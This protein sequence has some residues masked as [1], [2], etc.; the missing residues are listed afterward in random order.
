MT[1]ARTKTGEERA[2]EH[3]ADE[4]SPT[5][6]RRTDY[7]PEGV[8]H[9]TGGFATLKRAVKEFSEDNM[10]DWAAALTYYGLLSLFPALIAL[11]SIVGIFGDPQSTTQK[12]TDIVTQIGPQSAADTFSDPIKTITKDRGA[13][14]VLLIVG[15]LAALWSASGYTGAYMRASNII[16]ET[17]EGR[18]FW[19]ARPLQMLVTLVLIILMVVI[20]LSIALTGPIVEAVADPLG[21]GSTAVS[22]WEI[23]KWPV[24][25][26]LFA[27]MLSILNYMAPNV[28]QR[29]FKLI[30]AGS[31]FAMVVWIL[32]SILFAFYVANFGSYNKTY[33]ALG[34][35]ISLLVWMWITNVAILL[36]NELNAEI[37]RS[38]ELDEGVPRADREIQLKPRDEPKNKQTT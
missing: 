34:G 9:E 24:L 32:A 5:A 2:E 21:V 26:L 12:V 1:D 38:K 25:I 4:E 29:S 22:V 36:G 6:P 8:P 23:A 7:E 11:V 37:E 27:L 30:T 17:P 10:T 13:A 16:W 28:K 3:R 33:G 31:V 35:L 18:P 14:G 20:G 19:K 15:I